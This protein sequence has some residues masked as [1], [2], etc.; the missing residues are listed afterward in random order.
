MKMLSTIF[1]QGFEKIITYVCMAYF[2]IEKCIKLYIKPHTRRM[3]SY[4]WIGGICMFVIGL[5][6][7][8]S[9]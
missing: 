1:C 8:I 9:F 5:I 2:Y 4:C 3:T 6:V 7:A